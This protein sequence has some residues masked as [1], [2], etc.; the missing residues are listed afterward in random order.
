MDAPPPP[1]PPLSQAPAP[2]SSFY[3]K[4][5]TYAVCAPLGAILFNIFVSGFARSVDTPSGVRT[6]V[7]LIPSLLFLSGIPAAIIALCGIPTYGRKS[8]LWKGLVGL[9]FPL[10][11][12]AA[13]IP[14]FLKVKH[15]SE[16]RARQQQQG[17]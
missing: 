5:A 8:L 6:L 13:A 15:A 10:L 12:V 3:H 4:A 14:A 11:L 17:R 7:L 9:L 1:A 2:V 16:E